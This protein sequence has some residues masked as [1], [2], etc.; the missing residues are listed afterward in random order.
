ML[1]HHTSRIFSDS[2]DKSSYLEDKKSK[3]STKSEYLDS[4][5]NDC[6]SKREPPSNEEIKGSQLQV[7]LDTKD[8]E[9]TDL[10]IEISSLKDELLRVK[11]RNKQLCN[12]IGQGESK[13]FF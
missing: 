1:I 12:I 2:N 13:I 4:N 11:S 6:C 10:K 9:I 3:K 7:I 8:K 5:K